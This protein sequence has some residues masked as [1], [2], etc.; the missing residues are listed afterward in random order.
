[1]SNSVYFEGCCKM[2]VMHLVRIVSLRQPQEHIGID[3]VAERHSVVI[4]VKAVTGEGFVGEQ[5]NFA[6][7]RCHLLEEFLQAGESVQGSGP[8]PRLGETRSK[9]F[10]RGAAAAGAVMLSA[11]VDAFFGRQGMAGWAAKPCR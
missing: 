4:L 5:G 3:G 7:V 6:G 1:M 8:R 2:S 9:P 11:T 10:S